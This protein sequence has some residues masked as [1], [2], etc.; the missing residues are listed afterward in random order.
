MAITKDPQEFRFKIEA[1]SPTTMPL[2]RLTEYLKDLVEVFG[3]DKSTHLIRVEES[4]CVPVFLVEAEAVPKVERRFQEIDSNEAP[5]NVL[6]AVERINRKLRMDGTKATLV[7]P[8]KDNLIYFPGAEREE[9]EYGPFSQPGTLDGIPIVVGGT[10]DFVPVHL[11]GREGDIYLCTAPRSKAREIAKHLFN[12]I[13]R[14]EGVAKW[15]RTAEGE[16]QL[17]EFRISDFKPLGEASEFSLKKSVEQFRQMPAKWKEI[18]DPI[19]DFM[20]LRDDV[21][22]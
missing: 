12:T 14:V 3:E 11:Q 5:P 13:I 22:M 16:W 9:L 20:Q 7:G 1:Y 17:Q 8:Q 15:F 21:E 6:S 10:K 4:S 19:G 18:E 2:S